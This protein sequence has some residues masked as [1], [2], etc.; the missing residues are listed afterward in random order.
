MFDELLDELRSIHILKIEISKEGG[1][2]W[3]LESTTGLALKLT[4]KLKLN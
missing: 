3:K 4:K 1:L 2:L